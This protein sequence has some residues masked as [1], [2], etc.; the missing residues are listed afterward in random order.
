MPSGRCRTSRPPNTNAANATASTVS[1]APMM[2]PA[3]TRCSQP[4]G[5]SKLD[6]G[7]P[8]SSPAV[9]RTSHR[10]AEPLGEGAREPAVERRGHLGL[11]GLHPRDRFRPNRSTTLGPSATTSAVAG[12][13][14]T[15]RFTHHDP[16]RRSE[17]D[18]SPLRGEGLHGQ[19]SCREHVDVPGWLVLVEQDRA[20]GHG[21][22]LEVGG[23]PWRHG[24]GARGPATVSVRLALEQRLLASLQAPVQVGLEGDDALGTEHPAAFEP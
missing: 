18:P 23:E 8:S 17:A 22:A 20:V 19:A 13:P 11:L 1:T 10:V 15:A 9:R 12:P 16:G 14:C 4:V 3:A 21:D 24:V 5:S 6:H 2:T 7:L